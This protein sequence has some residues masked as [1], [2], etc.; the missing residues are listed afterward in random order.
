MP[1]F[2]LKNETF[3]SPELTQYYRVTFQWSIG[4]FLLTP[5]TYNYT[6]M[7]I[8]NLVIN[9]IWLVIIFFFTI[10]T[11]WLVFSQKSWQN[12]EYCTYITD[13]PDV[14]FFF[15]ILRRWWWW[16]WRSFF[17]FGSQHSSDER[18]P[19][20]RKMAINKYNFRFEIKS[21]GW[22][23]SVCLGFFPC[24]ILRLLLLLIAPIII[25]NKSASE[26]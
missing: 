21:K 14:T 16:C 17:L 22:D 5:A 8:R 18:N 23:Y 25:K 13:Q 1:F 24:K 3:K 15:V 20:W 11:C 6:E 7:G 26:F 4:V 12:W 10:T 19:H 9:F 2:K